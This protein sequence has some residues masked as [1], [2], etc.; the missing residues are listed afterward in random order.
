MA[1]RRYSS[2]YC[3]PRHYMK[4]SS[5]LHAPTALSSLK[6]TPVPIQQ[7]ARWASEKVWPRFQG[8]NS[9]L[10]LLGIEPVVQPVAQI[11]NRLRYSSLLTFSVYHEC[12]INVV[13]LHQ[14][15]MQSLRGEAVTL[16]LFITKDRRRS[17]ACPHGRDS[18]PDRVTPL[19][20]A[21][22]MRQCA[23]Q[24]QEQMQGIS[25]QSRSDDEIP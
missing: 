15:D 8:K 6:E 23:K 4:M 11:L 2:T 20:S 10:P 24:K 3:H 7:R 21:L 25:D 17:V 22:C 13:T 19:H 5:Q 9:I 18:G 12:K 14:R 16:A 1:K